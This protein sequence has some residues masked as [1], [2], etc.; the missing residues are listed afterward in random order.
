M[1]C[2]LFTLATLL[3]LLLCL[4]TAVLWAR[5]YSKSD[6]FGSYNNE[7]QDRTGESITLV[8]RAYGVCVDSGGLLLFA[9]RRHARLDLT[10]ES[11]RVRWMQNQPIPGRQFNHLS[12]HPSSYPFMPEYGGVRALGFGV[13]GGRRTP[14]VWGNMIHNDA[15]VVLPFWFVVIVCAIVPLLQ[16]R[17]IYTLHQAKRLSEVCRSCGYNLTGNTSGVCPECGMAVAGRLV[18]CHTMILG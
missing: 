17:A 5:S 15:F 10:L 7:G 11:D 9:L 2:K 16:L 1:R 18:L 13:M 14:P 3:S 12:E 8:T 6:T 4:A